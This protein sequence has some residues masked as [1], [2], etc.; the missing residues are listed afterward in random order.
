MHHHL[1]QRGKK[2]LSLCAIIIF[3]L[4]FAA[5]FY[6][7]G[8]PLLQY[9]SEPEQ[10][11]AWISSFGGAGAL[12]FIGMVVLQVFVAIIPGEPLEIGAGY[13]FGTVPGT[14]L[15]L[16]GI[17]IGTAL[18]FGFVKKFGIKA[19]EVFFPVEKI[20]S[21]RFLKSNSRL[22]ITA[23]LIFFIPGTPKDLL[24][25]FMGL[26]HIRLLPLLLIS[27]FARVPSV[28]TSTISGNALGEERYIFAAIAFG[29]TLLLGIVGMLIYNKYIKKTEKTNAEDSEKALN[30][31]AE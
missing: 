11:R 4:F 22:Y 19:L 21:M 12:I 20:N 5:A 9:A 16:A 1:T 26:T 27:V 13:A 31:Q 24:T 18:V 10:F 8:R 6:F 25:Y 3:V 2:I 15:C 17:A 29:I 14:M 7:I 28:L 23:C 30:E